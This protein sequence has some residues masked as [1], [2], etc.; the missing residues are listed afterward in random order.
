MI[1]KFKILDYK[2]Y[3]RRN[4]Q[5]YELIVNNAINFQYIFNIIHFSLL[6]V[7]VNM[8]KKYRIDFQ[9]GITVS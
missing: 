1:N 8:N 9:S 4:N 3:R 5:I 2:Q 6:H 7:N